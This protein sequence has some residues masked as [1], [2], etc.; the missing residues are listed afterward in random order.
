MI[1]QTLIEQIHNFDFINTT[2]NVIK[3]K[4]DKLELLSNK[5]A[6]YK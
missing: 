6:N 2:D 3:F 5:N 4:M 1:E